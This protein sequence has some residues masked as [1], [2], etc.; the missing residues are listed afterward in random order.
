MDAM[1]YPIIEGG[2][3]GVRRRQLQAMM[4]SPDYDPL[5]ASG[6]A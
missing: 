3:V 5:F 2:N 6:M 1:A 4:S